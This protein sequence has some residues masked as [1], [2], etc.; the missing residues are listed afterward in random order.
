M[1]Y[2]Y[3][4]YVFSINTVLAIDFEYFTNIAVLLINQLHL[5]TLDV[6]LLVS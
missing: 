2:A 4:N 1:I 6:S 5:F 3:M